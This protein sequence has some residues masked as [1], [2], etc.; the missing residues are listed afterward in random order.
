MSFLS[1]K[2]LNALG[3][4]DPAEP[5]SN[6]LVFSS[7]AAQRSWNIV[8]QEIGSGWYLDH[9]LY[10]FGEGLETLQPCLDAWPFLVPPH[11]DR[12]IIGRN[13]Y[14]ALL[15]LENGNTMGTDLVRVLDPFTA[16]YGGDPN[17]N[18]TSLVG[19]WLPN[20]VLEDFMDDR[21][22]QA[23]VKAND[24]VPEL[25]DV[26]GWKIPKGLGGT[27]DLDNLQ[28]DGIVDYY[29]TTAP[30]YAKAF[31]KLAEQSGQ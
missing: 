31:A 1:E 28:L 20:R 18:L 13:A 26:L 8:Q 23:W 14:G 24:A 27:M 4:P 30:I 7:G 16:T 10:L 29:Q 2:F 5:A 3:K 11:P 22:F 19:R 6:G 17:L 21:A 15:V 25:D 12:M 9:F